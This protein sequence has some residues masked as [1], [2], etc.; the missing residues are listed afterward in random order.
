V[1]VYETEVLQNDLVLA[2]PTMAKLFV[3]TT[4]SDADWIVKIIDVYPDDAPDNPV[5]RKGQRMGG[6]QQ[7]VRSE[8]IRGRFRNSYEHPEPMISGKIET[9]QLELQDVL[10]CFKKGHK[11]MIQIQCT[12][13]PLVDIN[14]QHYVD[15]IFQAK[16]T[17]FI[18]ATQRMYRKNETAS[19]IEIGVLE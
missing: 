5:T 15:N 1:L 14:P 4:G 9:I 18:K 6:Y 19:F 7:M 16:E 8:V 17:D 3:S 13:F 2:G 10:H 12:W 11:L